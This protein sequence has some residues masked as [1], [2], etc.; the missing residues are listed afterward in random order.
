MRWLVLGLVLFA[1]ISWSD[2]YGPYNKTNHLL[3]GYMT[4]TISYGIFK[5]WSGH[6]DEYRLDKFEKQITA[7]FLISLATTLVVT[8][9]QSQDNY[10]GTGRA[11]YDLGSVAYG[12][13]GNLMS[14][15]TILMFDF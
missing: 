12:V 5:S 11:R 2:V 15:G 7:A 8:A 3:L 4:T 6:H 10:N 13:G 1:N 14:V 9:V